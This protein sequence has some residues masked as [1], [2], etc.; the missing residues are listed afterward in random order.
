MSSSSKVTPSACDS[1]VALS[2]VASLVA[3][4]G[5]VN[6]EDVAARPAEPV[7]RVGGHDQGVRR[8]E[9]AGDADDDLGLADRAQPLLEPGDLDVV[10]LVAVQREPL[11]VVGHE[12][13][14]V[15]APPQPEVAARVGR[16]R[17]RPCGR[18]P[19]RPGRPGAAVVVEACP[20]AAAPGRCA[21]GRRRRPRGAGRRGTARLSASRSPHLVEHRLAVPGQV[22]AGLPLPGGG[23][24]RTPPGSG[25]TPSAPAAGGPRRAPR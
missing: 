7:H 14:A 12:R 11:R 1:R 15:D 21:S 23:V 4:P 5:M 3:N 10:G 24:E 17:S 8:V 9:P 22:G 20:A 16:A 13:E 2:L 19:R 6:G 25:S 18:R